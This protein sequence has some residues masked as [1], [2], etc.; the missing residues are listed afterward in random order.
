MILDI[1]RLLVLHWGLTEMLSVHCCVAHNTPRFSPWKG[2]P[3]ASVPVPSPALRH[4][5]FVWKE[6]FIVSSLKD[7]EPR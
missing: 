1:P 5:Y 4:G 2:F 3:R 7:L 6:D